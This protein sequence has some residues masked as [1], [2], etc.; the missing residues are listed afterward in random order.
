MNH[1]LKSCILASPQ[2]GK[3]AWEA[4][5]AVVWS[6]GSDSVAQLRREVATSVEIFVQIQ[7]LLFITTRSRNDPSVE[8]SLLEL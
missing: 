1:A 3:S 2:K 6:L 5:G 7:I 8:S 4:A